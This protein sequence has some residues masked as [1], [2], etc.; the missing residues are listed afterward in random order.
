VVASADDPYC[1]LG[2]ARTLSA[3]WGA[4]F[5]EVGRAGHINIASKLGAWPAGRAILDDFAESLNGMVR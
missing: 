1:A 4:G 3:A 2:I 5:V